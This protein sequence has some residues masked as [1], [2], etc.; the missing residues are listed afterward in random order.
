MRLDEKAFILTVEFEIA[1][2]EKD[3]AQCENVVT[4]IQQAAQ[5]NILF[6]LTFL[7][8]LNEAY[9]PILFHFYPTIDILEQNT[10]ADKLKE[11]VETLIQQLDAYDEL[12]MSF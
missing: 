11:K 10:I 12:E 2:D 1:V 9:M 7:E 8:Q 3:R 5:E 6:T 4:K